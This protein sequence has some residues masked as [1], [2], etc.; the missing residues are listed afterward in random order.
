MS[1]GFNRGGKPSGPG[2]QFDSQQTLRL[3]FDDNLQSH[4]FHDTETPVYDRL[5]TTVDVLGNITKIIYY[6]AD[7][8]E[9]FE[10]GVTA[11]VAGSLDGKYFLVSSAYDRVTFYIWYNV[12]GL[13]IDPNLSDAVG[14]EVPI[15]TGEAATTVA[16]A[17]VGFAKINKEFSYI[18]DVTRQNAVI[19]FNT[20]KEG[21]VTTNDIGTTSFVLNNLSEGTEVIN[22][23]YSLEYNGCDLIGMYKL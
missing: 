20:K 9:K 13:S 6:A 10:L 11:D 12:D 7:T 17:T 3:G 4:R 16:T 21:P 19:T 15:V 14:I 2:S 18:F 22:E 1:H 23:I 8:H 5:E